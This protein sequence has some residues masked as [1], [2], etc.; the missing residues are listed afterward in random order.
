MTE[1]KRLTV[2]LP[3]EIK[4]AIFELRKTE[5]FGRCSYSEIV[6]Q[7]VQRGLEQTQEASVKRSVSH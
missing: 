2:S 7:L 5:A 4:D 1:M 6:R 3:N